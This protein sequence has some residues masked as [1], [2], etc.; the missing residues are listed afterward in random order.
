MSETPRLGQRVRF[1]GQHR[2]LA[3][4]STGMVDQV[5]GEK[6]VVQTDDGGWF[7]WTTFAQWEPTGEPDVELPAYYV[8]MRAE[9]VP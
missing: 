4:G 6:F 7:F 3:T 2:S 5:S 1:T 9:L 8:A